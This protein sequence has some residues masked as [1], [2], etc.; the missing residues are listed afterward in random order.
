MAKSS[1]R[2]LAGSVTI[3]IT[4]SFSTYHILVLILTSCNMFFNIEF[5]KS[6]F[7]V[8]S[9]EVR[10]NGIYLSSHRHVKSFNWDYT[11]T[12]FQSQF[13]NWFEFG[14]QSLKV[15]LGIFDR[16]SSKWFLFG[17][18]NYMASYETLPNRSTLYTR[19]KM[20]K[21]ECTL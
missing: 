12:P 11:I 16:L 3:S 8:T 6:K 13:D 2:Q 18:Q 17:I 14:V 20:P 1:P 4:I 15:M 5:T 19:E 21:C 10:W 9:F 7:Y